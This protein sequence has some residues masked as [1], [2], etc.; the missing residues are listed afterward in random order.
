[1]MLGRALEN[2]RSETFGGWDKMNVAKFLAYKP[3]PVRHRY[4]PSRLLA[5]LRLGVDGE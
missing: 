3:L 4:K 5:G 2:C 1:L